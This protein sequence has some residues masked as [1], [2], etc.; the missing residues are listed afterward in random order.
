MAWWIGE[1]HIRGVEGVGTLADHPEVMAMKV[2]RMGQPGGKF[3][4]AIDISGRDGS[5]YNA[6]IGLRDLE[7]VPKTQR[8]LWY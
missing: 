1:F 2:D 8:Q 3:W 6:Q 7:I 4:A 5:K